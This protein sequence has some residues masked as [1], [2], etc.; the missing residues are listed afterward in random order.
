MGNFKKGEAVGVQVFPC[1][2][3]WKSFF[4]LLVGRGVTSWDGLV[5]AL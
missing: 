3:S 1:H 4:R 5:T 2:I